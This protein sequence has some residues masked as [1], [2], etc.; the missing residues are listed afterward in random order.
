MTNLKKFN[1]TIKRFNPQQGLES[2]E[3]LVLPVDS[4]DEEHAAAS[5]MSNVISFTTKMQGSTALPVAFCCVGVSER[6]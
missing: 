1:V 2:G 3:E 4:P 5:V 6:S